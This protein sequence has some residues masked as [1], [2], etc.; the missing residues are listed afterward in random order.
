MSSFR[1]L[2]NTNKSNANIAPLKENISGKMIQR[3]HKSNS[4]V[5][6]MLRGGAKLINNINQSY[7]SGDVAGAVIDDEDE[8]YIADYTWLLAGKGR[9]STYINGLNNNEKDSA[10]INYQQIDPYVSQHPAAH[11]SMTAPRITVD[12]AS[13]TV[14]YINLS[15]I[16]TMTMPIE[17]DSF[18]A[19]NAN[20]NNTTNNGTDTNNSIAAMICNSTESILV[21]SSISGVRTWSLNNHPLTVVSKY[22][23]RQIT[24]NPPQNLGFLRCGTQ[25]ASCNSS[26]IN[27]WDIETNQTLEC[28]KPASESSYY[29]HMK[30]IS[31]RYGVTPTLDS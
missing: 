3:K 13:E 9:W 22:T 28:L 31:P 7:T 23:T 20:N 5:G 18:I 11:L 19:A 8:S 6:A 10:G 4:G 25:L 29:S 26:A 16:N 12:A 30:V 21:T 27:I 17:N 14:E 1:K 24:S 2:L 15:Y